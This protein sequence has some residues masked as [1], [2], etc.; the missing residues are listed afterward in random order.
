MP[1]PSKYDIPR[2][3]EEVALNVG[4]RRTIVSIA[5]MPFGVWSTAQMIFRRAWSNVFHKYAA[6]LTIVSYAVSMA[7]G[8]IGG[9]VA[10][11]LRIPAMT[12]PQLS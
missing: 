5:A 1:D 8:R 3:I 12:E 10:V 2:K 7:Y 9:R 6:T 4:S 11:Q